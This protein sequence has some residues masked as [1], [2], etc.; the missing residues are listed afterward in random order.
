M[1]N[2]PVQIV[3]NTQAMVGFVK[4][5]PG[6]KNMEFYKNR[7]AEFI[8]HRQQLENQLTE[9]RSL[10]SNL[11]NDQ[12]LYAKVEM[13]TK[14]W[15]KSNRPIKKVFPT[16]H[17][18]YVGGLELGSMVVELTSDD[19]PRIISSIRA[20]EDVTNIVFDKNDIPQ[21]KP[22]ANRSEVGAIQSIRAYQASDRRKF[23]I[24]GAIQWLSRPETGGVYLIETFISKKSISKRETDALKLRGAV[25][26]DRFEQRLKALELP[27]DITELSSEWTDSTVYIAKV[28]KGDNA[29]DS[30]NIHTAFLSFLDNEQVVKSIF[31]PPILQ[32]SSSFIK[33]NTAYQCLEPESNRSYPVVGII[34]TGVSDFPA[35]EKWKSGGLDFLNNETQDESHGTFIAGLVCAG[36]ELN[37]QNHLYETKCKFF[38]M[39][40]YPTTGDFSNYY[41]RGFIDFLEQLDQEIPAAKE[42]GARVFNMSL[43]VETLINDDSYSLFAN[44]LDQI[45]DKH[46]IIF[47]LP[48][49]NLSGGLPR[50]EWPND[51]NDAIKIIADYRHHGKDRIFQP[52]DSIRS[53]V[54]GALDP[55]LADGSYKPASYTRRGPGPSLGAKPDLAHIGGRGHANS[56]LNSFSCDGNSVESCGTSYAA[57]LVAKTIAALDHAIEG[58]I[59]REALLALSIHHAKI[60][61]CLSAPVLKQVIKDLLGAGIPAYSSETLEVDDHEITL[62]FTGVM[63]HSHELSF[64]FTWPACLVNELGQ[65]SGNVK[66]TLVYR[67]PIDRCFGGEFVRVNLDAYLR[68]EHI[69]VKTGEATFKGRLKNEADKNIEKELVQQGSK[70]WPVKKFE[71]AFDNLGNSSQWKLVVDPL[72]R[73]QA[74]VPQE[75]VE[76][77]VVLTI[78]DAEGTKPV[79]NDMRLQLQSSPALISD[80]RTALRQRVR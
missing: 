45:A 27:I 58:E 79:F 54:V 49:G 60:P 32:T 53:L 6:G 67:P 70:W 41:P 5:T 44:I 33:K 1:A 16:K 76:F 40:L 24:D 37:S 18:A 43:S 31:L 59:S 66:L 80:I 25:A 13:Q 14:A 64:P 50:D 35:I 77:C 20:A 21:F 68:Q 39:N 23:T 4:Q 7:D 46:D 9:L 12:V 74:A 65:C 28:F 34:D 57:P 19:I 78:S 26:L 30:K 42:H 75:G 3:L 17:Q 69:N 8:I 15:A 61:D 72:A 71:Q 48:A 22:S 62:V 11:A 29:D 55:Q 47:A 36:D 2:N 10:F 38:D 63:K 73:Y 56:G 51:S 52:A